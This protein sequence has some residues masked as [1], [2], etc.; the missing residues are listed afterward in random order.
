MSFLDRI[1]ACNT[2]DLSRYRPF[3]VDGVHI[4]FVRQDMA[5]ALLPYADTFEVTERSVRLNARLHGFDQRTAAVDAAL[6]AVA[7][8]GIVSAWRNE[9]YAVTSAFGAPALFIM[10]RAAVPLFGIRAYGVHMN[11]YVRHGDRLLM[12]IGRRSRQKPTYPGLLDNT[13]A[14]GLP[15]GMSA[16][17]CLVKECAE[18][19]GIPPAWSARAVPVGAITYCAEMP[20]GLRPDVQF[21]YDLELPP[22][23][24]P[25]CHDGEIESFALMPIEDVAALVRDTEEFKFN[26]NLVIIDFLVRHG[27]IGPDEPDYVAIVQGLHP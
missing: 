7:R 27:L 6:R 18:E 10:E 9:P 12:W 14:G 5:E 15:Y 2:H 13:V 20:E 8:T 4:G 17:E 16:R 11:G 1:R 21:C 25:V 24:T 19:A 3:Q 23:F 22:V 26:C